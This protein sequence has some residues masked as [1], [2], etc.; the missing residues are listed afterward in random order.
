MQYVSRE[1]TIALWRKKKGPNL[2]TQS[3]FECGREDSNLHGINSH[4]ALNLTRLP[5]PPRPRV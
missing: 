1:T 3:F 4:Q 2:A 5:I